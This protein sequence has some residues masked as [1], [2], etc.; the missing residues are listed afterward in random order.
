MKKLLSRIILN[1]IAIWT[2]AYF[3]EGISYSGLKGLFFAAIIFGIVNNFIKPILII[4][5]F[6]L[7]IMT[8]GLFLLVINGITVEITAGLSA[9]SSASFFSSIKAG[10]VISI[11]NMFLQSIFNKNK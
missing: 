10:I 5:S 2:A 6:P 1:M 4:I 7:T 8:F 11:A 3:I 9:L